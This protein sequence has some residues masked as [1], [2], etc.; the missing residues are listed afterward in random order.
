[1]DALVRVRLRSYGVATT[2]MPEYMQLDH[3]MG[4]PIVVELEAGTTLGG[5]FE[6][7]PWLGSPVEEVILV[8]VNDQETALNYELQSGDV[9]DLFTPA[10]G[11]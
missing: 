10:G 6:K 1:M 5:M 11:G 2:L 9:I 8:F 7:L 3:I 4:K